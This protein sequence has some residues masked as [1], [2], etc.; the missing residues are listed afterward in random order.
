VVLNAWAAWC[1]AC[2]AEFSLFASAAAGYGR[3]VAF[4]GI[5][6]N[7]SSPDARGF[8]IH[9]PVSY[10]SLQASSSGLTKLAQLEGLPTTIFV[11]RSGRVVY[12]H[13]GAYDTQTT[14]VQDI[15][16]YALR[17]ASNAS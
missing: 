7:D 6:T 14:L 4:L 11:D 16:R 13:T 5:D 15:E 2:R 12:V 10:P 3:R 9:H 1:T 8:L 17:G